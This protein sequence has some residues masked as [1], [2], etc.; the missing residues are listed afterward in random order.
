VLLSCCFDGY[1]GDS[2]PLVSGKIMLSHP[3]SLT[4]A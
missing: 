4:V 2:P 1:C 3:V